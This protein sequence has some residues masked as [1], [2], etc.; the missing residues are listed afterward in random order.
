MQ[1]Q[2]YWTPQ[3]QLLEL[4]GAK[5]E[6]L[7]L[8]N[9]YYENY[10]LPSGQVI[11]R[12]HSQHASQS[13]RIADLP[14]LRQG[15]IYNII[16]NVENS[17]R[18]FSYLAIT[19]FDAQQQIITTVSQNKDMLT[20]KVP[21]TYEFYTIDLLSAGT[22]SFR[23]FNFSIRPQK[24]GVLRDQDSEIAAGLYAYLSMPDK[25]ASKTLRV[26]FSEPEDSSV[27]YPTA[28]VKE[29]QQAVQFITSSDLNAKYYRQNES[30]IILAI[31]Q[32]RKKAHAK[33]LEF[34]GYGPISSY[35]ALYYQIQFKT[36]FVSIS[37]DVLLSPSDESLKISKPE[38]R[39]SYL[40]N[41]FISNNDPIVYVKRPQY[42]RLDT[43]TYDTPTLE[44]V[45][46]QAIYDAKHPQKNG[47]SRFLSKRKTN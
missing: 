31:K 20:V 5:V 11:A 29:T 15:E 8:N 18:M 41:P 24:K 23:F 14:Q 33:R 40:T 38:D 21:D 43:L 2:V 4:Q 42:E 3:T 46:L 37:E 44:E 47:L 36:S 1:Y 35:A 45:R 34:V 12:W 19:F 32:A 6:F 13:Q 28:Y 27:D 10:F 9:V 22:G 7:A 26:I 30:A 16:R 17:E 39:V 25:I